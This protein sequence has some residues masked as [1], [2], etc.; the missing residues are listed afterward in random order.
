[1]DGVGKSTTAK[2]LAERLGF[3]FVEKPLHYLFDDES[4]FERYQSIA[5]KVNKNPNRDFTA[6]FYGLGSIFMYDKFKEQNII[7][8]RHL[9]S[10]YAWSGVESNQDI[11][12]LLIK[13]LGVPTLTIILY[14]PADVIIKRLKG[15]DKDDKDIARAS[16]SEKIYKRMIDFCKKRKFPFIRLDSSNLSPEQ[17]VDF[18]IK[19]LN[20]KENL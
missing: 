16:E 9:V 3:K 17:A 8:D 11:Y 19:K 20:F 2:L 6:M 18:I 7:T 10:N 4:S 15:R 14:A 5:S 13:K 12:D 1:M